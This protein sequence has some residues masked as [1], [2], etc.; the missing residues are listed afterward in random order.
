MVK[1][2]DLRSN[3]RIVRVGSNPTPGNSFYF[4]FRRTFS[5][6][7]LCCLVLSTYFVSCSKKVAILT[8]SA[9]IYFNI[10]GLKASQ[11]DG[12]TKEMATEQLIAS[13]KTK[14]RSIKINFF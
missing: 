3:G 9:E 1:A 12:R 13:N 6:F 10:L 7:F 5:F 11:Y 2:L 14:S 4:F 8:E